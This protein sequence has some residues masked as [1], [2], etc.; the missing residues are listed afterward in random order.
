MRHTTLELPTGVR[1]ADLPPEFYEPSVA[2]V[3]MMYRQTMERME[4]RTRLMTSAQR[5]RLEQGRVRDTARGDVCIR[6]RVR[7]P[8]GVKVVGY[9]DGREGVQALFLWVSACLNDDVVEFDLV[10][11]DR[12]SIG[13]RRFDAGVTMRDVCGGDDVTL[14]LV[15]NRA[16]G[17]G[18]TGVARPTFTLDGQKLPP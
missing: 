16:P 14:N 11:P 10:G 17:T 8:E 9:F 12:K 15:V 1:D 3:R 2:E 13:E 5:K 4:Q 6:V 18:A 7:A